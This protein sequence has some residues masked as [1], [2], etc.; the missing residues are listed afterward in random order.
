MNNNN[1]SLKTFRYSSHYRIFKLLEKATASSRI[2]EVGIANGFIGKHIKS[3]GF[4][5]I[6]IEKNISSIKQASEY[7]KE[8]IAIDL[9]KDCIPSLKPFVFII[10]ADILE[11]LEEP[12]HILKKMQDLLK[13]GGKIIISV[14]N[15]ANWTIRMKLA[16]GNFN[17][18]DKGI[19]DI[20]HLRF[21]TLKTAKD[22][23]KN[24]GL[25][26]TEFY[27]TPIPLQFII[28]PRFIAWMMNE[29]YYAF[30]KLFPNFFAYQFV[31]IVNKKERGTD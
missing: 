7:Y 21:F 25:E 30:T 5:I 6:G 19:L 16:F 12:A 28:K 2:L 24:S 9:N 26:M 14:P 17:Y 10:L 18:Q 27:S 3:K 15:I 4:E 29:V 13:D 11:H 22:M 23:I 31:F 1:Y 8:I 20:G